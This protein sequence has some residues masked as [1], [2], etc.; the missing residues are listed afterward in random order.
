MAGGWHSKLDCEEAG[1][2]DQQR[3]MGELIS[4]AFAQDD[5]H[6]AVCMGSLWNEMGKRVELLAWE[7][8]ARIKQ[9]GGTS[10]RSCRRVR[11]SSTLLNVSGTI[12][13]HIMLSKCSDY[14]KTFGSAS[15]MLCRF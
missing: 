6:E 4:T 2:R 3:G 13:R 11:F 15:S 5:G 10:L 8:V 9:P 12:D 7:W 1:G 14:N